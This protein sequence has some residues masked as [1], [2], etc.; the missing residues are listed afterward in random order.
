MSR[1]TPPTSHRISVR[2]VRDWAEQ[3]RPQSA[4]DLGLPGLR[5]RR[6][7]DLGACARLLRVVSFEGWCPPTM[8]T[9]LRAWLTDEDVVQAWVVERVGEILGHVAISRVGVHGH[10]TLRWRDV[11]GREADEM[12][13]VSRF[14]VRGRVRGRGYGSAL[15]GV[16]T[17]AVQ[18]RGRLPVAEAASPELVRLFERHGWTSRGLFA[19]NGSGGGQRHDVHFF[20]LR[21]P[22][23]WPA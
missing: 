8:G 7:G 9:A 17:R 6:P 3:H 11:T 16:A 18:E 10:E 12:L 4:P 15:L 1:V 22:P 2:S 14:F 20:E 23:A 19:E 13:A 21:P 5:V